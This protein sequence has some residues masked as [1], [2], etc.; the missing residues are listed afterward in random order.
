MIS[1]Y[2]ACR[3]ACFSV[4][5]EYLVLHQVEWYRPNDAFD[6]GGQMKWMHVLMI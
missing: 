1:C 3:L 5:V 2:L 6:H 4:K